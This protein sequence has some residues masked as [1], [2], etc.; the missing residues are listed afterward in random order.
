MMA[1][2]DRLANKIRL[3]R[4]VVRNRTQRTLEDGTI[5]HPMDWFVDPS[6][7]TAPGSNDGDESAQ[8]RLSRFVEEQSDESTR[9]L[10][11]M[12]EAGQGKSSVLEE[13]AVRQADRYLKR[14]T[15]G[16]ALYIDA[17]GRGLA[18]LDEV[19][20]RQ[21]N[22]LQFL[23][24]YSAMVVLVRTGQ[25]TL[26]IDG[27][28]ELIG[29]R[30]TFDDAFRSLNSFLEVLQGKGR[31]V[32]AG[33]STYFMQEFE[34]RGRVLSDD[35][36]YSRD[37]AFLKS[38]TQHDQ[39]QMLEKALSSV[40]I[41]EKK[42]AQVRKQFKTFQDDAQVGAL[43]GR[44]L[45]ARDI[46][47]LLL[48]GWTK[49]TDLKSEDLIPFLAEEY[50]K[51]EVRNKLRLGS[52]SFVEPSQLTEYYRELA[53]EMWQLETRE[54]DVAEVETIIETYAEASWG[55]A[56]E[57]RELLKARAGK[58]PFLV[59]GESS[60]RVQ[61]EHEVFFGFFLAAAISPAL[62]GSSMALS[63]LG[64]GR[65]DKLT[66]DMVMLQHGTDEFQKILFTLRDLSSS[67]H[68]RQGQISINAGALVA[69]VLRR[70]SGLASTPDLIV[71]GVTISDEDLSDL[72]LRNCTFRNTRLDRVDLTGSNFTGCSADSLALE[73]VLVAPSNTRL[74]IG[75]L[76]T[77]RQIHGLQIA[78][79]DG[80]IDLTYDPE[81]VN[82]TLQAIGLLLPATD[83]PRFNVSS[84]VR[85]K[86]AVILKSFR[87]ANPV[88]TNHTRFGPHFTDDMGSDVVK[89]LLE[90]GLI[91]EDSSRATSGPT[92]R[93]FRKRFDESLVMQGLTATNTDSEISRFWKLM[94]SL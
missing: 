31:I 2:L 20:A 79:D 73:A 74:E 71:D 93:F 9:I 67:R 76:D 77:V 35:L 86:V 34:N 57:Q 83:T 75:G 48:D 59:V 47:F 44:P 51:R 37:Q 54:L 63:L 26:V 16:L 12:A 50:I 29:S 53:E 87:T 43:L 64:K 4:G 1:D 49:P 56:G 33:R 6:L 66:A 27:F 91:S 32:A 84:E 13:F 24:G 80:Q 42:K 81:M 36:R 10:F 58:L 3:L 15:S 38:W 69:A 55:L 88:G 94:E 85:D 7:I 68:P 40:R 90:C 41:S 52:Q 28:D 46:I 45:F 78:D 89:A 65:L 22:D 30:G 11:V 5:V 39:S 21:L 60:R 14:E 23:L 82:Q 62:E 18:R 72:R 19:I 25:V 8:E 92:Q 17:Q 61:F 70:A